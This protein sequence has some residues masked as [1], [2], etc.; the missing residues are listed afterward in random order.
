MIVSQKEKLGHELWCKHGWRYVSIL[1]G[2][3]EGT[4]YMIDWRFH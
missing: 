4:G 3:W 2:V 1:N